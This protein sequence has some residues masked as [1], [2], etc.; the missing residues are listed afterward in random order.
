MWMRPVPGRAIKSIGTSHLHRYW[1]V[2]AMPGLMLDRPAFS[3][4]LE[5]PST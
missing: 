2:L 3:V 1:Y 4:R 5:L